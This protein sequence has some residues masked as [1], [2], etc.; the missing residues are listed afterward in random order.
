MNTLYQLPNG[1]YTDNYQCFKDAQ[2]DHANAQAAFATRFGATLATP[3]G[4]RTAVEAMRAGA[5]EK[6]GSVMV[7]PAPPKYQGGLSE[8]EVNRRVDAAETGFTNRHG[9]EVFAIPTGT[10]QVVAE[11]LPP[12]LTR[13]NF[14]S[15]MPQA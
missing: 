7:M 10:P 6:S 1:A 12:G 14:F 4:R 5:L 11:A 15:G 3:E 9:A 8:A 2:A 13:V